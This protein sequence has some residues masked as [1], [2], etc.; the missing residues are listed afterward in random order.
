[1]DWSSTA[2]CLLLQQPVAVN[3]DPHALLQR[4]P[5]GLMEWNSTA[6]PFL[7]LAASTLRAQSLNSGPLSPPGCG[8]KEAGAVKRRARCQVSWWV[9]QLV[10]RTAVVPALLVCNASKC[11]GKVDCR[12]PQ[13]RRL[14]ASSSSWPCCPTASACW[15]CRPTVLCASMPSHRWDVGEACGRAHVE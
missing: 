15:P 1:M 13:Q 7:G 6:L 14:P 4:S 5:E 8:K 11:T 12:S 10:S 3:T 9:G 2:L